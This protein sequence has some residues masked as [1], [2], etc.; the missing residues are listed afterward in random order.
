[1]VLYIAFYEL[2]IWVEIQIDVIVSIYKNWNLKIIYIK[3]VCRS[4]LF[5]APNLKQINHKLEHWHRHTNLKGEKNLPKFPIANGMC[6]DDNTFLGWFQARGPN[7]DG[8]KIFSR[9][10]HVNDRSH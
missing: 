6:V 4:Q 3:I 1:M 7:V 2:Y 10:L 8:K 5:H 9:C